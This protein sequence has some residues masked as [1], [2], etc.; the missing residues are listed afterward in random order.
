MQFKYR[1]NWCLL[2]PLLPLLPFLCS[3]GVG[4]H[5]PG[6]C[7]L[8]LGHIPGQDSFILQAWATGLFPFL[9]SISV[10]NIIIMPE[11]LV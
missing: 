5:Q 1:K 10:L 4:A 2:S 3:A 7:L 8:L 6:A 9:V 11:G